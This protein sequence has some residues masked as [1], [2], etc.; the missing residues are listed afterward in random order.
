[1]TMKKILIMECHK[2]TSLCHQKIFEKLGYE[3]TIF[4]N[5][6][7]LLPRSFSYRVFNRLFRISP[8][9]SKLFITVVNLPALNVLG[10]N[11][12][13]Y[14]H[15]VIHKFFWELG[16]HLGNINKTTLEKALNDKYL[17]QYFNQFDYFMCCFPPR[18][19]QFLKIIA[20]KFDKKIILN[21]GHRFNIWIKTKQENQQLEQDLIDLYQ[22]KKHI[23]AVASEYDYHYIKHY[24]N[25][26]VDRL[27]L[28]T[29]QIE[30]SKKTPPLTS[31]PHPHP[32]KK[33]TI[34]IAPD[35]SRRN[36]GFFKNSIHLNKKY[37]HF[38]RD[39]K[40]EVEFEFKT[41][42]EEFTNFSNINQLNKYFGFIIFPY[43]SF[44]ILGLELYEFNLPYFYPAKEILKKHKPK[45]YILHPIYCSEDEYKQING[46]INDSNSPNN[47]A[48]EAQD[49]WLNYFSGYQ[50]KNAIIF[51]DLDDLFEKVITA[52]LDF[53]KIS[54]AMYN[55]NQQERDALL[56]KWQTL[57]N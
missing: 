47:Y 26:E 49:K 57:L 50:H 14:H 32:I 15:Y 44:S 43:S 8:L 54:A 12:M 6:L 22:D 21:V 18:M 17:E 13:D 37:Q 42:R 41:L 53:K 27:Y 56:K 20:N 40:I 51:N 28:K 33:K 25:I 19:F 45:D 31:L 38:C 1:M 16:G 9:L 2:G 30:L 10:L 24:L 11:V 48:A 23:L 39:N 7:D 3:A 29:L 5:P 36:F 4:R 55:E 34:L 35:N 46:D 52:K